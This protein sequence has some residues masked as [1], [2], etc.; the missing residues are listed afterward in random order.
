MKTKLFFLASVVCALLFATPSMA[1]KT[2]AIG[3]SIKVDGVSAVVFALSDDGQHGMAVSC[4]QKLWPWPYTAN[5]CTK[6]GPSWRM[7][8]RAELLSIYQQKEA[9]NKTLSQLG[10]TP[11]EPRWYWSSEED[12]A[13]GH[14][15]HVNLGSGE[16]EHDDK[17]YDFPVRGVA[18]F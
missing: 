7:P 2:Y 3:D 17:G 14:A 13:S 10:R 16:V 11:I 12:K 4:R 18:E 15:W 9:L 6:M 1:Q 5:Y 8:T